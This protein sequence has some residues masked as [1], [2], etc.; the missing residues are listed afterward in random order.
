MHTA[1]YG[2]FYGGRLGRYRHIKLLTFS[3]PHNPSETISY[4]TGASLY[5]YASRKSLRIIPLDLLASI[6]LYR[7]DL[8]ASILDSSDVTLYGTVD[9][10]KR[11]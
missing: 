4:F 8:I 6:E 5:G 7:K 2:G 11:S 1:L 10:G 9:D 3:I